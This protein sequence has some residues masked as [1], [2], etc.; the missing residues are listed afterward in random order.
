MPL[1]F[2][3]KPFENYQE[4][5][6]AN[7]PRGKDK[8]VTF[9]L[10]NVQ[11]FVRTTERGEPL[12]SRGGTTP[13]RTTCLATIDGITSELT[14]YE[15]V[16]RVNGKS[17]LEN[18][19]EPKYIHFANHEIMLDAQKKMDKFAFLLLNR[20]N[21]A[22]SDKAGVTPL[23]R[24]VDV[25]DG[26]EKSVVS[27]KVKLEALNAVATAFE[28]NKP[29]IRAIYTLLGGKDYVELRN[30]KEWDTILAPLYNLADTNPKKLLEYMNSA[31]LD[32]GAQV[33]EGI[34][35]AVIR[36]DSLGFYWGTNN[37]KIWTC[38]SGKGEEAFDLFV[39]WL[40]TEDK[41][42]VLKTI[43]SELETKNLERVM[44]GE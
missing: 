32:V 24:M 16:G 28:K 17:G 20:Y 36:E 1:L 27:G 11:P 38:P 29:K 30:A 15:S 26:H 13:L 10:C 2:N 12:M 7:T 5:V 31:A 33:R 23:Y 42:G 43:L 40:R 18:N 3:G 6:K 22:Q 34:D 39:S 4:I 21:E 25:T 8:T 14:Y 41:S 35:A 37:K 9:G 44:Q 19:Y